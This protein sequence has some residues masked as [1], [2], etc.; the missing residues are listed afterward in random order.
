MA[1]TLVAFTEP[2]VDLVL[3]LFFCFFLP[4]FSLY[5]L[6][7]LRWWLPFGCSGL[8]RA[9]ALFSA[10]LLPTARLLAMESSLSG[11]VDVMSPQKVAR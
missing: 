1:D 4:F 11:Y 3:L 8:E 9:T 2:T 7:V 5:L 10:L 6:F